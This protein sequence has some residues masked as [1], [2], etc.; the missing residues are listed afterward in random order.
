MHGYIFFQQEPTEETL[1]I[2]EYYGK[3]LAI[4]RHGDYEN[5]I[6][7]DF[8]YAL[9]STYYQETQ[10]IISQANTNVKLLMQTKNITNPSS[11]D[12]VKLIK[13]TE[14]YNIFYN[15]IHVAKH[16][17]SM[18]D[19]A[20]KTIVIN[21]LQKYHINADIQWIKNQCEKTI[22]VSQNALRKIIRNGMLI[23]EK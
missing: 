23:F 8:A 12:L 10:E 3:A 4:M 13:Q 11:S 2:P 9:Y 17:L 1:D 18:S 19:D 15:N 21:P 22:K 5:E 14:P 20:L 7:Q 16:I 6:V